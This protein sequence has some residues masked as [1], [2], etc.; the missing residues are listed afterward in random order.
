MTGTDA[1]LPTCQPPVA[2]PS[3]P[4]LILPPGTIDSHV[5]IFGPHERYP[6]ASDRVFTP[7]DAPQSQL[8]ALHDFLGVS[9]ALLIQSASHGLD[10]AAMMAALAQSPDRYRGVALLA[11]DVTP[12]ALAELDERGICGVRFHLAAHMGTPPDVVQMSRQIERIRPLCWHVELHLMG[13]DLLVNLDFIR[14]IDA[15]VVIDHMARV[16][17]S[18]GLDSPEVEAL[19]GLLDRSNVWVKLSGYERVSAEPAPYRDAVALARL[20]ARHAPD[21]VIWGTD[22]PH[23]NITGEMVDDGLLVDLVAEVA[24]DPLARHKLLVDNAARLFGFGAG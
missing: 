24:P 3:R 2:D 16:D 9:R 22:Y 13:S 20:L 11:P 21:R 18:L 14:A 5:H 6:Y 15:P 19:T 7:P 10:H 17:I 4:T 1:T 23:P 12:A 8:E